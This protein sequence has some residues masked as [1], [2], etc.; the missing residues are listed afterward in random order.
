M[1]KIEERIEALK[2]RQREHDNFCDVCTAALESGEEL[3]SIGQRIE[4]AMG[5]AIESWRY[6]PRKGE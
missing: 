5:A 4:E 3:C 6:A 2:A 1:T